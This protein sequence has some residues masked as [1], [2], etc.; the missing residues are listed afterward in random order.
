MRI[1]LFTF[2]F[3]IFNLFSQENDP[4]LV[5]AADRINQ[6]IWV[7]SIYNNMSLDQ[8][9]G[10]LFMPMVFSRKDSTHYISS[11]ELIKKYHIGGII[12]SLGSPYKQT[13]WLNSFQKHSKTP[14]LVGMDAE[15]GVS[16]RLDSVMSFPWNMT[17]G[18]I[19]DTSLI[20]KI[21]YRM[22]IQEKRLGV[23]ISFSP[24]L[25]INT[26]PRNPIIGNRSFGES[27]KLVTNH[28]IALMQGHHQAG[29]LTS[30]K[31]F[32]GHGDTANDSHK[33][34]PILRHDKKRIKDVELYPYYK[35][36][37]KGISSIMIAHLNVPVLTSNKN[38]TSLS[39]DLIND[40]L[41]KKMGFKGLII[42][43]ALNMD[44]V[45]KNSKLKNV[46]LQAFLA[47]NDLLIVSKD[48]PKG[49][50]AIKKSYNK[51]NISE[52]RLSHSVKKILKAKYKVG[53]YNYK[54]IQLNNITKELN[55]KDDSIL[56]YKA[57]KKSLTLLK[58]KENFLP[59]KL[60][61]R[62][63]HISL[64][65]ASSNIYR[66][67]LNKKYNIKTL[68]KVDSNNYEIK[69]KNY[70]KIIISFHRSNKTPYKS[71]KMNKSEIDL[72][73]KISDKKSIILNLFVK[74]YV[75]KGI[76]G[77]N[78]ISSILLSYQ[79][80][81][82]AQKISVNALF[83]FQKISGRLP[84]TGSKDFVFNSGIDLSPIDY[85]KYSKPII[86]GF[87]EQKL[88]KLDSLAKI[89]IDSMMTPG[90]Q[91]LV[92]RKGRIVFHK[93]YGFHSYKKITP[94]KN[95]HVYD[96]ASLTKIIGT[97]PLVIKSIDNSDF[98]L[99]STLK[100]LLPEF[101]GTNKENI[102]IKN[103]L[104]HFSYFTPWIPF[105]KETINKRKKPKRKFYRKKNNN[106]FS[107]AV[108]ENLYIRNSYKE[109]IFN[110]I[111]KSP[112]LKNSESRY[113]DLPFYILKYYYEKKYNK[114][115]SLIVQDQ[116]IN[117]LDLKNTSYFPYNIKN[118]SKIVPSEIDNYYRHSELRG[119]VHDMG[120]AMQGGDGG[121][122]GLFSN[123]YD[124]AVV[125][126][127]YLQGG[128]YNNNRILSKKNIDNFNVCYFCKE[129]NR[130]GVGFDKPQINSLDSGPTFG[131][132]SNKSFGHLGF[133][134]TY[135]W[136]DPEN[137]I[138]VVFL[139]NR[140]YPSMERNLIAKH[141]IRTRMQQIV[142][143]A[144]T[145]K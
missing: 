8:K 129:G 96:I 56:N 29:I 109:E 31:H 137:E 53:L 67:E 52:K 115:F 59:L 46:D 127:M 89:A 75:L 102:I 73:K 81:N 4:L 44:G 37:E 12:F 2:L 5:N 16:M 24:V 21:G 74:P 3:F 58:N 62:I 93:S 26:N 103:M 70:D 77:L 134:G 19:K 86:L 126:Q 7:D 6:Y 141:D 39:N 66:S 91:M 99:N 139:S 80:S 128:K 65:D 131:G 130:R 125:M 61:E 121:H 114:D 140:T 36:I 42:T 22:G 47:G 48:I 119:Y 123:A 101:K 23:H 83:G 32:P 40:L 1:F 72:I 49:F 20:R 17:L 50:K 51:G 76:E 55:N 35:L 112:I 63:A 79:N 45:F 15:W 54:P 33:T 117:P 85:L 60:D 38:P 88:N 68:D 113:S 28:A 105:Y 78:N 142:Y 27:K 111:V 95:D 64:G 43:D 41:K 138:I 90:I 34:L 97:L 92:A 69:I 10:Q 94:V 110:K 25:D 135:T 116:V 11:L 98:D 82:I 9:I 18:A 71:E 144:L 108:S 143:E 106:K 145:E 84:V 13:K 107:T 14:L 100:D 132:A 118:K 57:V 124:I 133:T 120:A 87:N 104:S 122:A 30:G 136:A